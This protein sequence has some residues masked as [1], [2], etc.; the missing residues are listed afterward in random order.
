MVTRNFADPRAAMRGGI[1]DTAI[2]GSSAPDVAGLQFKYADN[3]ALQGGINSTFQD[4]LGR[5]ATAEELAKYGVS[6]PDNTQFNSVVQKIVAD[7]FDQIGDDKLAQYLGDPI[8]GDNSNGYTRPVTRQDYLSKYTDSEH[9]Y[10]GGIDSAFSTAY[11]NNKYGQNADNGDSNTAYAEPA[12]ARNQDVAQFLTKMDAK[13]T[14]ALFKDAGLDDAQASSFSSWIASQDW[15]GVKEGDIQAKLGL[16]DAQL[17]TLGRAMFSD[18]NVSLG[19]TGGQRYQ[20]VGRENGDHRAAV[21]GDA[22]HNN[23]DY[24]QFTVYDPKKGLYFTG[25]Y[26]PEKPQADW[27]GNLVLGALTAG[28]GAIAAPLVANAAVAAFP[29]LGTV[30]YAGAVVPGMTATIAGGA[31]AGALTGGLNADAH[32]GSFARGARTGGILGGVG[33][34]GT[35]AITGNRMVDSAISGAAR[36]GIGA[37]VGGGNVGTGIISGGLG[38]AISP[39]VRNFVPGV[40]G[41]VVNSYVNTAIRSAIGGEPEP[42][43]TRSTA[44]VA[45]ST[46]VI[47]PVALNNNGRMVRR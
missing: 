46:P 32:G 37:A 35:P 4:L 20:D 2:A 10:G 31:A 29:A 34:I 36:G 1:I 12:R 24:K 15:N 21:A 5:D 47:G 27:M 30:G 16:N 13:Q 25:G 38:G 14:A 41:N 42:R 28:V 11:I 39:V 40:A 45:T 8:G 33:A 44:P 22:D 3:P 7:N 18:R 6:N 26:I 17:S 9:P 23:A 19:N 43:Q